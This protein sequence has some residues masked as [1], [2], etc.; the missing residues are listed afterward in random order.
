M[1]VSK[2]LS[3]FIN[4]AS[5][6]F[7]FALANKTKLICEIWDGIDETFS[8]NLIFCER[9]GIRKVGGWLVMGCPCRY[10]PPKKVYK[11]PSKNS[12]C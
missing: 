8:E 5:K 3:L 6:P 12:K 2:S 4:C 11:Y 9:E 1:D 10:K 7:S